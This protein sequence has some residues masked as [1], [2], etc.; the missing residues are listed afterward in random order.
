MYQ[1]KGPDLKAAQGGELQQVELHPFSDNLGHGV[2]AGENAD[3]IPVGLGVPNV[4][5]PHQAGPANFV[6]HHCLGVARDEPAD[7][8][9]HGPGVEVCAAARRVVGY[10][11]DC[12]TLVVRFLTRIRHGLGFSGFGIRHGLGFHGLGCFHCLGFGFGNPFR[13]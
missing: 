5:G 3:G 2:H 9:C 13:H 7:M 6:Q 11:P 8:S 12:L 10:Y 1:T 4:V